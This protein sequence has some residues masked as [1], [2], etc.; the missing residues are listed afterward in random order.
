MEINISTLNLT[1]N[2]I[3]IENSIQLPEGVQSFAS[4][5]C[6]V[7]G[8]DKLVIF[9]SR[10]VY[11]EE[12]DEYFTEFPIFIVTLGNQLTI[13]NPIINPD[14]FIIVYN[15]YK[16]FAVDSNYISFVGAFFKEIDPRKKTEI[17]TGIMTI[18]INPNDTIEFG[19]IAEESIFLSAEEIFDY[20][21]LQEMQFVDGKYLY[22]EPGY[23]ERNLIEVPSLQ[24]WTEYSIKLGFRNENKIEF[25]D[26]IESAIGIFESTVEEGE[27]VNVFVNGIYENDSFNLLPGKLYYSD[28]NGNLTTTKKIVEENSL[29]KSYLKIGKSLTS[30]KINLNIESENEKKEN[31]FAIASSAGAPA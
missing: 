9:S 7:N 13:S 2:S 15:D 16:S 14:L 11:D 4:V 8:V 21:Y 31:D 30:K 25:F 3:S 22:I 19:D 18:K 24:N 10:E 23:E 12:L 28:T 27:E 5:N 29:S 6:R 17:K 20:L 1:S 26:P